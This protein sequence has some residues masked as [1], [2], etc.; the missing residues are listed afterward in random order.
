MISA[1]TVPGRKA[2]VKISVIGLYL[3]G[4]LGSTGALAQNSANNG[5]L[6]PRIVTQRS[7]PASGA[8]TMKLAAGANAVTSEGQCS[9][10]RPR[11]QRIPPQSTP[12]GAPTGMKE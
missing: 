1:P 10:P 9:P 5:S 11:E 2:I 8:E 7:N 12:R 3:L 4:A 6:S